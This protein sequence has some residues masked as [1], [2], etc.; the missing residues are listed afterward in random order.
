MGLTPTLAALFGSIATAIA[1]FGGGLAVEAYK[2]RQDRMGMALALAGAIDAMLGLI[3]TRNMTT[4]L[5]EALGE[6][7]AGRPVE[8]GSL[9]HDN[10]PFQ[11]ITLSYANQLGGLRGD[12]P[13]RVAR[14][15]TYSQGLQ[16]DLG[17]FGQCADKPRTQAML[18]RRMSPLWQETRKLGTDLVADLR[19]AAGDRQR[20]RHRT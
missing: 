20:V 2:R 17:R 6:L 10:A 12:L 18:I 13:F 16:H 3:E 19:K 9:I 7:E 4:E 14:F 15:L 1:I 8:F 11:A 5:W